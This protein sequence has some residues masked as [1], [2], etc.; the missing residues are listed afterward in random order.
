APHTGGDDDE[1]GVRPIHTGRAPTSYYTSAASRNN[2]PPSFPSSSVQHPPEIVSRETSGDAISNQQ[3]AAGDFHDIAAEATTNSSTSHKLVLPTIRSSSSIKVDVDDHDSSR[4]DQAVHEARTARP[5]VAAGGGLGFFSSAAASTS[6]NQVAD[7]A[8]ERSPS[9]EKAW[10]NDWTYLDSDGSD[11][12]EMIAEEGLGGQGFLLVRE[13]D[14]DHVEQAAAPPAG[15]SRAGAGHRQRASTSSSRT[16]K[17]SVPETRKWLKTTTTSRRNPRDM[18]S[19]SPSS[20]R[21]FDKAIVEAAE[22]LEQ[23]DAL[24]KRPTG[25][26]TAF[27]GMRNRA[28]TR[29]SY[30]A[31]KMK[32]NGI[33]KK[34]VEMMNIRHVHHSTSGSRN[35]PMNDTTRAA[36]TTSRSPG[37]RIAD[38]ESSGKMKTTSTTSAVFTSRTTTKQQ[39][40]PKEKLADVF[41]IL[42]TQSVF[43]INNP[44]HQ[45]AV[46]QTTLPLAT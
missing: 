10:L 26:S 36:A 4:V 6:D 46:S 13:D 30:L 38:R 41:D 34:Q 18:V 44:E 37:R 11:S 9:E 17:L 5:A 27:I 22:K 8:K 24:R 25:G 2:S 3:T 33:N 28:P 12:E 45:P 32:I 31:R 39:Q 16:R 23:E 19:E 29:R 15:S 42:R 43:E 14:R 35:K 1:S 21:R 40:Y 7:R 20:V